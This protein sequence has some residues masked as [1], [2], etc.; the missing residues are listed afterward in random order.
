MLGNTVS[1]QR[2]GYRRC[3]RRDTLSSCAPSALSQHDNADE[4][5]ARRAADC[6]ARGG[7]RGAA[8]ATHLTPEPF[9]SRLCL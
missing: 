8:R 7:R 6:G 3:S 9:V 5:Q 1:N 2:T 4:G